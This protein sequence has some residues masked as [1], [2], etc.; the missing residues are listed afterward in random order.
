MSDLL[1]LPM[2][3]GASAS[4]RRR[5]LGDDEFIRELAARGAPLR[6]KVEQARGEQ[7]TLARLNQGSREYADTLASVAARYRRVYGSG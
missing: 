5:G 4:S 6:R 7:H 3:T 1:T 2:G